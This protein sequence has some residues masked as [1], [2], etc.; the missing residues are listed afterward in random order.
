M[1][2]FIQLINILDI[3]VANA[4]EILSPNVALSGTATQV[5]SWKHAQFSDSDDAHYAID[6]NFDTDVNAGARCVITRNNPRAWWKVDLI[7]E[8]RIEKVAV[9][10]RRYS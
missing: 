10:T 9:T 1:V 8:H 6:G 2:M 4:V 5:S 7:H 3:L